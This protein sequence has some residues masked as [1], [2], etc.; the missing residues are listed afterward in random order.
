MSS[1]YNSTPKKRKGLLC[2]LPV[3]KSWTKCWIIEF[4]KLV[5]SFLRN[6]RARLGSYFSRTRSSESVTHIQLLFLWDVRVPSDT[7]NVFVTWQLHNI[8]WRYV[9]VARFYIEYCQSKRCIVGFHFRG[10]LFCVGFV[11]FYWTF[12]V[13]RHSKHF[14][15]NGYYI[16]WIVSWTS[17]GL[18]FIEFEVLLPC[19]SFE[20]SFTSPLEHICLCSLQPSNLKWIMLLSH[21]VFKSA[22]AVELPKRSF[23]NR[24]WISSSLKAAEALDLLPIPFRFRSLCFDLGAF[25]VCS[26]WT[27]FIRQSP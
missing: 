13:V 10:S 2:C 25:R 23:S 9:V 12:L 24:T 15:C 14:R 18:S 19:G 8:S 16:P 7:L 11:G 21:T 22:S 1:A 20:K 4:V 26:N 5:L 6:R 27:F 17:F 3:R